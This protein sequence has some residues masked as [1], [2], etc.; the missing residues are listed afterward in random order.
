MIAV[1]PDEASAIQAYRLL[2]QYGI[3]PENLA[4]VGEGYSPPE[5][6]GLVDPIQLAWKRASSLALIAGVLGTGI[7]AFFPATLTDNLTWGPVPSWVVTAIAIGIMG[8]FTGA[9][10]G[11]ISGFLWEG[12]TAAVYRSRLRRGQYLL[13]LEGPE[14]LVRRG[15]DILSQYS[16]RRRSDD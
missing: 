11:A 16:V 8:S 3:S 14:E 1:L 5:H 7:G 12:S 2:Q 13:M 15:R 9:V 10:L 4:V 6:V